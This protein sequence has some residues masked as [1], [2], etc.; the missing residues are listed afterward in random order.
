MFDFEISN[1]PH[2]YNWVSLTPIYESVVG[3]PNGRYKIEGLFLKR[4]QQNE[5]L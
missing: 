4:C 3:A 2:L 5:D 1:P